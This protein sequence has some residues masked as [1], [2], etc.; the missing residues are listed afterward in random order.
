MLGKGRQVKEGKREQENRDE[1]WK[2]EDEGRW[3]G[4]EE[5]GKEKGGKEEA[6]EVK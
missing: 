3:K 5:V 6:D 4:K 1:K 2:V